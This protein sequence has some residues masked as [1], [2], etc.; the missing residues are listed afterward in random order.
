MTIP[1]QTFLPGKDAP[2]EETIVKATRLLDRI[3]FPVEPVSWLNPVP[4]CWSI[5]LRSKDCGELYTNGKG[6]SQQASLASALGEYLE[7]L[8]SNF[9]F[10][11]YFLGD[12]HTENSFL[13]YPNEKWFSVETENPIPLKSPDG[14]KLLNSDLFRFYDPDNELRCNH[15]F[16]HNSSRSDRGICSLPFT[17]ISSGES[18][19]FPVSVLNN[20][21][22]SN[23]MAAGNSRSECYSQALSEI[24]ERY[25]KNHVI[26]NG[27]ALPDVPSKVL[28]RY[29]KILSILDELA[30]HHMTVMVKDCS[31]GGKFPVICV[32]LAHPTSGGAYAAFGASYRFE[33]AI[34]RTLTELL[35]GRQL[36]QL[37]S[38]NSPIHDLS[39][40]ADSFNL[41]SH[42][43]NSDGLLSWSMFKT[44]PDYPFSPWD[45]SGTTQKEYLRLRTLIENCGYQIYAADYNHC[46]MY[47]CRI[48]VPGMSEI[49]PVDDLIWNNRNNGSTIRRQL[50]HLPNLNADELSDVLDT[51][52]SMNLGEQ[53][54]ISDLIGVLFDG[55]SAWYSLSVGELRALLY[56]ALERYEDAYQW[57]N[58]CCDHGNLK[59]PRQTLFRLLATIL[60]L[61]LHEGNISSYTNG[62]QLYFKEEEIREAE[63]I[64]AAKIKF[65]GLT[66]AY[67]WQELSAQHANMLKLYDRLGEV[68][69]QPIICR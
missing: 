1:P 40:A 45:F 68:K 53:Y 15:L 60:G 62:L 64:I 54:R 42:F 25:V 67:S 23:G 38:F 13:Y 19:Y 69:K 35:Q 3:G 36:D 59:Q 6:T 10:S 26:A 63:R 12:T 32:L 18:I 41:E 21:Y 46:G 16:D 17:N 29:P 52:E 61:I 2:L 65:P 48:I 49:Y 44:E 28:K 58:W 8:S 55:D 34:E 14:L 43:I 39:L 37:G 47:G 57:C 9:F 22:V 33:N 56:L 30:K 4:N 11:D 66:F 50:L 5:H 24:V 20:L 31:L 7:R 51:L 27:V